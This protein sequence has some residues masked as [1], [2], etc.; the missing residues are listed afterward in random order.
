MARNVRPASLPPLKVIAPMRRGLFLGIFLLSALVVSLEA[1]QKPAEPGAANWVWFDE[2]DP[3]SSAPAET[4]YFRH[5]F[6]ADSLPRKINLEIT[7]DNG[8]TV[9]ING[10]RVGEGDQWQQLYRFDAR[11]YLLEG[12]NVLA[13]EGRNEGGPAGLVVKLGALAVSGKGWKASKTA[14]KGW[15]DL[16][17]DEKDWTPVKVIGPY[18]KVGPW[19]GAA[20]SGPAGPRTFKV[21]DG[22]KVE[23]A[24]KR[25]DDRGPF[26]LVN[27][28][29]DAKGRL[30]LSQEG[31]PILLC[32][33]PD[34]DGVYQEV[35][36]Y[37]KQV[38]NC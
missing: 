28:C 4:R 14:A 8:F 5:V 2:G 33:N 1:Q 36:E 11:K 24:G 18:G 32:T 13:V 37:C 23:L 20:V 15:R 3:V 34:K 17:F 6:N 26:S 29:F 7:A 25:P 31:G 30:L 19:G 38:K 35:V 21:P 9:W 27:M 16:D 12:K 10:M 22:F